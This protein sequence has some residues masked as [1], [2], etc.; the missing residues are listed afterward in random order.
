M[1]QVY[2]SNIESLNIGTEIYLRNI[3]CEVNAKIQTNT[4]IYTQIQ[5]TKDSDP[6]CDAHRYKIIIWETFLMLFSAANVWTIFE[7]EGMSN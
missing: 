6:D 7:M 3:T 4:E 2:I 5:C 1:W